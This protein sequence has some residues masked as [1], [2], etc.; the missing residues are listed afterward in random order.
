MTEKEIVLEQFAPYPMTARSKTNERLEF[1]L[2]HRR[3]RYQLDRDGGI[4]YGE[5]KRQ[6]SLIA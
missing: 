4:P 6:L 2:R 1:R 5:V 3:M